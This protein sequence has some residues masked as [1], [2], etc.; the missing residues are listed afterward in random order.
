MREAKGEYLCDSQV[1]DKTMWIHKDAYDE[2]LCKKLWE[3]TEAILES[4]ES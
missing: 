4:I 1:Y 3:T 2:G